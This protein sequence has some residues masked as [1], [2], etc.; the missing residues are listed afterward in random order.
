LL[1]KVLAES[2]N[3]YHDKVFK[4]ITDIFHS[5]TYKDELDNIVFI[6]DYVEYV[7]EN[8]SENKNYSKMLIILD[9]VNNILNSKVNETFANNEV[10]ASVEDDSDEDEKK[11]K[12]KKKIKGKE[13]SKIDPDFI[14]N[15]E[16]SKIGQLAKNISEKIN[17]EDYPEIADP[18]KLLGAFMNNSGGTNGD[19]PGIQ[20]LLKFV[21][22]EVQG[23]F[24]DNKIDQSDL[25][26]EAQSM[27][28]S[29]KDIAGFDPASLLGKN[30]A[31]FA[32]IF[33]KMSK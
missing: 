8:Y 15:L 18:S 33:S 14:K 11:T 32:D 7:K 23:A 17:I 19:Q 25:M 12:D 9:N 30:G 20:N 5:L 6:D 27:M 13:K 10:V 28:G 4:I 3:K 24:K 22:D 26:N 2:E 16:N 21:I 29:L 31:D 1:K